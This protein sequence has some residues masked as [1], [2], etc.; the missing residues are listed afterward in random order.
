MPEMFNVLDEFDSEYIIG[1]YLE[2]YVFHLG[3]DNCKCIGVYDL[4]FK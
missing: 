1:I 2:S 4:V 3:F